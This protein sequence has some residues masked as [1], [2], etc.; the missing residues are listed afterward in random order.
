M[1]SHKNL[2]HLKYTYEYKQITCPDCHNFFFIYYTSK[3]KPICPYCF[4]KEEQKALKFEGYKYATYKVLGLDVYID[5]NYTPHISIKCPICQNHYLNSIG[6]PNDSIKN[7]PSLPCPKCV[8]KIKSISPKIEGY[9]PMGCYYKGMLTYR[10]LD[11]DKAWSILKDCKICGKQHLQDKQ[12]VNSE[13]SCTNKEAIKKYI[14]NVKFERKFSRLTPE[15]F[16]LY[17]DRRGETYRYYVEVPKCKKC[18]ELFTIDITNYDIRIKEDRDICPSCTGYRSSF[19]EKAIKNYLIKQNIKFESEKYFEDCISDKK[20][21][22]PFDFY[23]PNTNTL[24]EFDG[25]QHFEA[26][27]YF[28]GKVAFERQQYLDEVKN[29]YCKTK[30]INLIRIPYKDIE[31]IDNILQKQLCSYV[32]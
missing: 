9:E 5:K 6:G 26:V 30:N 3:S 7:I 16:P 22:L 10:K 21:K 24:I 8:E 28:G 31:N 15:G 29:N 20:A 14:A 19:G 13:L 1:K 4:E 17:Y 32:V 27:E 2:S 11:K 23:L 18:G 25:D 12:S